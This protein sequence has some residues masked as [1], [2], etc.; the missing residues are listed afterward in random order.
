MYSGKRTPKCFKISDFISTAYRLARSLLKNAKRLQKFSRNVI[1][2]QI[3]SDFRRP[4]IETIIEIIPNKLGNNINK[5]R[6]CFGGT[7]IRIIGSHF[8][9]HVIEKNTFLMVYGTDK[10][11]QTTAKG[12]TGQNGSTLTRIGIGGARHRLEKFRGQMCLVIG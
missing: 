7:K 4:W 1:A 6:N 10:T 12:I 9:W 3:V 2:L 8:K 5:T 11:S